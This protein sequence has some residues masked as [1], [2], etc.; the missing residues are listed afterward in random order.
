MA[1]AACSGGDAADQARS[2]SPGASTPDGPDAPDTDATPDAPDTDATP[3][4]PAVG[5]DPDDDAGRIAVQTVDGRLSTMR[6]DGSDPLPLGDPG[7]VNSRPT[8]SADASFVAWSSVD[9][10]DG[11]TAVAASRFDGSGSHRTPSA[12]PVSALSWDPTS[13]SVAYLAGVPTGQQ[14]SVVGI[15][16]PSAER[17]LDTGSPYWFRWAPADDELLVHADTFRLDR[18]ALDGSAVAIDHDTGA[19]GAPAWV[20]RER[21][22]LFAADG[23]DADVLVSSGVDGEGRLALLAFDGYLRIVDAPDGNRVAVHVD[24]SAPDIAEIITAAQI[25]PDSARLELPEQRLFVVSVFGGSPVAVDRLPAVA[26]AWSPVGDTLAYLVA[27]TGGDDPWYEW[28]F[29]GPRGTSVGPLHRPTTTFLDE[30]VPWF[31]QV[32]GDVSFFSPDGSRFVYAGDHLTGDTGVHVHTIATGQTQWI[33]DGAFA[34]WSPG[35]AGGRAGSV[36]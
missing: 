33:A 2:P 15:G 18:V 5:A 23:G 20:D 29:L 30:F 16:E 27:V 26:F 17:R 11:A 14:L 10:S 3:P 9:P 1:T 21:A 6:P 4:G 36:L 8:W 13:T 35:P 7:H 34:T 31:D 22:L 19:F 24:E 12:G 25:D 28:R 32:A